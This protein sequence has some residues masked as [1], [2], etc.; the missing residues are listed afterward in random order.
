M[1]GKSAQHDALTKQRSIELQ[2]RSARLVAIAEE[3]EQQ[4]R[5]ELARVLRQAASALLRGTAVAP[6]RAD[7]GSAKV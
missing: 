1:R 3:W 5:H 6:S 2:E 7:E 4:G